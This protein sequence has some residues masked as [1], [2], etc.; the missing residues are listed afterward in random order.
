MRC[1]TRGLRSALALGVCAGVATTVASRTRAGAHAGAQLAALRTPIGLAHLVLSAVGALLGAWFGAIVAAVWGVGLVSGS[2]P[3]GLRPRGPG[4]PAH[5]LSLI[6]AN[7]LIHNERFA[8]LL[9]EL[10]D[11]APDVLLLQEVTPAHA[12]SLEALRL[13]RPDLHVTVEPRADYAGWATVSRSP[14]LSSGRDDRTDWPISWVLVDHPDTPTRIVNVH[15]AAPQTA[16]DHATWEQQLELLADFADGS[17]PTILAGDFN[18]TVDHR[19]FRELLDAG[20]TDA[21][22]PAGRGWGATWPV[23]PLTIP[24]LRLDHVLVNGSVSVVELEQID[25]VGSDHRGL[26]ALLRVD[27]ADGSAPVRGS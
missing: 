25:L 9:D 16:E 27:T 2:A 14:F 24:L 3:V 23:H 5:G 7:V 15:V 18:A 22:E 4:A 11:R 8:E 19:S 6:T 21:F 13:R 12:R 10:V 17:A 20:F 26:R 1:V